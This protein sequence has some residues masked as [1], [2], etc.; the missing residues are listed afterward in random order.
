[1]VLKVCV[2]SLRGLLRDISPYPWRKQGTGIHDLDAYM[3]DSQRGSDY[4]G[5]G[6][7]KSSGRVGTAAVTCG[8]SI[9]KCR[10]LIIVFKD[11]NTA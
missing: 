7:T 5:R 3:S 11:N 4:L 2:S 6:K 1:M 10:N 8:W 9:A